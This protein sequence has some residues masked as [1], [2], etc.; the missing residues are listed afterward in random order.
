MLLGKLNSFRTG[1]RTTQ[2]EIIQKQQTLEGS[3]LFLIC[4][5][6]RNGNI[7]VCVSSLKQL[8]QENHDRL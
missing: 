8:V 4:N 3:V 2:W 1:I 6:R 5:A 7:H